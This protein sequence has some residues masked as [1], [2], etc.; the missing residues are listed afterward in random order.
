[1]PFQVEK[2]LEVYKIP[3]STS[4]KNAQP[5]WIQVCCPIPGCHD[6][7]NHGGLNISSGYYNCWI[8]GRHPMTE[9]IRNLVG[10]EPS[11]AYRIFKEFQG[12]VQTENEPIKRKPRAKICKWPSG[13]DDMTERHLEYLADR[14]FNPFRLQDTWK[15]M[16]TG[17]TGPY[18]FRIIAPI[19]VDGVMI[20]YQGRDIT[21]RQVLRYKACPI[22]KEVIHHKHT[23]YGLDYITGSKAVIVEG[24]TDVWKLGPGAVATFGT[25]YSI[26]QILKLVEKGITTVQIIFDEDAEDNADKLAYD[27]GAVGIYS[28]IIDLEGGDPGDLSVEDA[29]EIMKFV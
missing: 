11:E 23:L 20:S 6:E 5:G 19:F 22:E 16:G 12:S 14:R 10:I 2:F 27:L 28:E 13:C 26:K 18:K 15:L 7:S 21:D 24:V 1:M 9:V 25:E 8:C 17:P 3:S 4:G 29:E